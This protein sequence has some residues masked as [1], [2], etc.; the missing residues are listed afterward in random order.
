ME[1]KNK[2]DSNNI[3]SK[4]ITRKEELDF[5]NNRLKQIDYF[6]NK[7]LSYELI[8]R[9]TRDGRTSKIF[10]QKCDGIPKTI[11]LIKTEKGLI[12]GGYIE[13]EWKSSGGWIYDDEN[14]FVF[15]LDLHKIYN[16]VKGYN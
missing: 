6:K 1:K 11:T 2:N 8:F 3:D 4:I 7:N 15:S 12:F 9:G 16:P 10:H 14:C 5:I 13:K